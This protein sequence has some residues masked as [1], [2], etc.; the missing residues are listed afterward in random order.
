MSDGFE[1]MIRAAQDFFPKLRENNSKEWFEP[2]KAFYTAQIKKPAELMA[3]L[4]AEDLTRLTGR[5]HKAKVFRIYRDVRFSK[6][7][8]P[9]NAHLHVSWTA[10]D[11]PTWFW[12]LSPDYFLIGMGHM[13]FDGPRLT[14]FRGLIDQR[15]AALEQALNALPELSLSD[16]GPEPLKRVPKPYAA[17]H[18]HA[19]WLKRKAFAVHA[20]M[21]TDWDSQGLVK[22]INS[23]AKRMLPLYELL[24]G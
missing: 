15:G 23:Q 21:P 22:A 9:L 24:G 20:P 8:T 5:T 3:D 12:G 10:P 7:K 1:T 2:Q 17:D 6:D 4:V 19:D 14:A 13:G 11:A 18:P 16:F